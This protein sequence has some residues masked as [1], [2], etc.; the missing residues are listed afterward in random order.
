MALRRIQKTRE[1]SYT[2]LIDEQAHK[3][4][5]CRHVPPNKYLIGRDL[6]KLFAIQDFELQAFLHHSKKV[7]GVLL[8]TGA[9]F[10]HPDGYHR[11]IAT[12]AK[13]AINGTIAVNPITKKA[14]SLQ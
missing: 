9:V 8:D 1:L 14:F 10:V 2:Q 13:N 5:K 12:W 4:L 11:F 6:C 7:H 3:A